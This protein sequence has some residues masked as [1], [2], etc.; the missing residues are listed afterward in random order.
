MSYDTASTNYLESLEKRGFQT[1]AQL[2]RQGSMLI[3]MSELLTDT[4]HKLAD[5][6][7]E[8]SAKLAVGGVVLG[9]TSKLSILIGEMK[10]EG[11]RTKGLISLATGDQ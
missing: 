1:E 6:Q 2:I 4:M 9:A 3:R 8:P 10:Q 7:I 5:L 11:I